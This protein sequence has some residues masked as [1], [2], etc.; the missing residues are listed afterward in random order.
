M[1]SVFWISTKVFLSV[2][3]FLRTIGLKF[4]VSNSFFIDA[5]EIFKFPFKSSKLFPI[6]FKRMTPSNSSFFDPD[7]SPKLFKSILSIL[8]SKVILVFFD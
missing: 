3:P 5:D 7:F 1:K 4:I 2:N 6:V 8:A